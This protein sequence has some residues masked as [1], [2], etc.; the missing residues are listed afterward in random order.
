MSD[1]KLDKCLLVSWIPLRHVFNPNRVKVTSTPMLNIVTD[2]D[3]YKQQHLHELRN[4]KFTFMGTDQ[5]KIYKL[6]Q[7]IT[8]SHFQLSEVVA[9]QYEEGTPFSKIMIRLADFSASGYSVELLYHNDD[10]E[11]GVAAKIEKKVKFSQDQQYP[12]L[13]TIPSQ[14]C[15]LGIPSSTWTSND[16]AL[17]KLLVDELMRSKSEASFELL[18]LNQTEQ[19]Q[20]TSGTDCSKQDVQTHTQWMLRR[21]GEVVDIP[22]T[23]IS[24]LCN[25]LCFKLKTARFLTDGAPALQIGS[26]ILFPPK[27]LRHLIVKDILHVYEHRLRDAG[28]LDCDIQSIEPADLTK[29]KYLEGKMSERY[30]TDPRLLSALYSLGSKSGF[31]L[32]AENRLFPGLDRGI[33]SNNPLHLRLAHSVEW[34]AYLKEDFLDA[35]PVPPNLPGSELLEHCPA[36]DELE[37]LPKDDRISQYYNSLTQRMPVEASSPYFLLLAAI[38]PLLNNQ[39]P[40]KQSFPVLPTLRTQ[41][42]LLRVLSETSDRKF[43]VIPIDETH[44]ESQAISGLLPKDISS[45]DCK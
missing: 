38:E 17:S 23:E 12:R 8:P 36:K 31:S 7:R 40:K 15:P 43:E 39:P 1:N 37:R 3:S 9:D 13:K 25:F 34:F 26:S 44:S 22:H 14:M 5:Q 28:L 6:N 41:T 32:Q 4:N 42:H 27:D 45:H 21:D 30:Q 35:N 10:F 24:E 20:V 29:I 33:M 18:R 19:S 11:G 2:P 16:F